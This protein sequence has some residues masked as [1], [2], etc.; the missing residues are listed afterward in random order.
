MSQQT[1]VVPN[2][3]FQSAP[4]LLLYPSSSAGSFYTAG[5]SPEDGENSFDSSNE[6]HT[7]AFI[8]STPSTVL[9]ILALAVGVFIALLF[10]Y[11][12]LRCF[13]R[14]KYGIVGV[15]ISG[16]GSG[17]GGGA[18]RGRLG[19]F[20][21]YPRAPFLFTGRSEG[22]QRGGG[23][24]T[25]AHVFSNT[26]IEEQLNY[27]RDHRDLRADIIEQR[28]AN[29]SQSG[30]ITGSE[31]R[32]RR[33][34][35]VRG[36][37]RR[38]R[39]FSKMKKLTMEEVEKLFPKKSYYDWLNGGKE[40]DVRNREGKIKEEPDYDE[41]DEDLVV[42]LG[43]T[44]EGESVNTLYTT[45][46]ETDAQSN[47]EIEMKSLGGTV[48][49]TDIE[50]DLADEGTTAQSTIIGKSFKNGSGT[51][52]HDN[53]DNNNN[54][55]NNNDDDDDDEKEARSIHY[56]SGACAICLETIDEDEMVRGLICGHVFHATCIDPWVTRRRACCPMCKRD[57]L[58]KRDYHQDGESNN[59]GDVSALSGTY[60]NNRREGRGA[61]EEEEDNNEDDDDDN[62]SI[63]L[64]E[65]RTNPSLQAMLQELVP[66]S[67]RVRITLNDPRY[68]NLNLEERA[69]D[70]ANKKYGRFFK[71]IWWKLVGIT[72][73]DLFNWAVLFIAKS[74]REEEARAAA[75]TA[76]AAAVAAASADA[77]TI[78][79][80][81][82]EEIGPDPIDVLLLSSPVSSNAE[83]IQ[84]RLQERIQS[85]SV[86]FSREIIENRV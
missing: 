32:R 26:E 29:P 66:I 83:N 11:F 3:G 37:G 46:E 34:R 45:R 81:T 13:V 21:G 77:T 5:P 10:V 20:Y 19:I 57:Y 33:R 60:N 18:R 64:D 68:A 53:Y 47:K 44:D 70:M 82:S 84:E 1:T 74:Y 72:K 2:D 41:K 17:N 67:E 6:N 35:T 78:M 50:H 85:N 54:N 52:Q 24:D 79:P 58:F 31:Y 22:E 7:F 14:S 59:D 30:N 62:Y 69:H 63:D 76:A 15:P 75:A 49:C 27:I 25:F 61:R 4:T 28:L 23:G 48:T 8:G 80:N 39:R 71:I 56:D 9:F 73:N 51:Q 42:N 16:G 12:T 36:R 86:T 40:R 38:N 65:I 43:V 55:N